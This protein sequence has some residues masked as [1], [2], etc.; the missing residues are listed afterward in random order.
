MVIPRVNLLLA[1]FLIGFSS[2]VY[3]IYSVRVLFMFFVQ[4]TQA[5]SI[6]IS[7]F[8]GGIAFSSIIFSHITNHNSRNL[9]IIYWL[10][11]ISA[12][13]GYLILS[14][15][16]LIPEFIDGFNA[17][18]IG[19]T[20]REILRSSI[21]WLFLFIPAFFLGGAFPLV[22]GLYLKNVDDSSKDTGV[23]YFW[24]SFGAI[25]GALVTGYVLIPH[26]GLEY[27]IIIPV[28]CNLIICLIVSTKRVCEF[29][30]LVIL[31]LVILLESLT[32][33]GVENNLFSSQRNRLEERFGKVVFNKES[34][35]G[36]VVV[37]ER[38]S[39]KELY[40]DYQFMC[41]TNNDNIAELALKVMPQNSD[42]M[43]VGF[44]CGFTSA[45]LGY[46]PKVNKMDVVEINPVVIEAAEKFF[47]KESRDILKRDNVNLYIKDGYEFTRNITKHY[48]AII[49]DIEAPTAIYSSAFFTV[50]FFESVRGKL[51]Q[52]GVFGLWSFESS[53][54]FTRVI[55]NSLKQVFRHVIIKNNGKYNHFFATNAEVDI[56]QNYGSRKYMQAIMQEENYEINTI[57]S[58]NAEKYY[59]IGTTFMV[60]DKMKADFN[61][62]LRTSE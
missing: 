30:I 25:I 22:N 18:D 47:R 49:V 3:Q 4:S 32:Y 16:D 42:V 48:D 15:Y 54:V 8:L 21:I 60:T 52:Q 39:L 57:A 5:A 11:L 37:T 20:Y 55:Y 59:N 12:C 26:L 44:G 43:S 35:F 36:K 62:M 58:P 38:G 23:V 27:T 19:D 13:Y 45:M 50:D 28:I 51:K 10:Q 31:F 1:I 53:K 2:L 17:L 14:Q 9:K 29:S 41:Q 61:E 40:I 7:A 46:H 34:D 56:L 24:D 33:W 6:A